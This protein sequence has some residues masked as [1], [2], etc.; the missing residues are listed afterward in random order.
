M[1]DGSQ[2]VGFLRLGPAAVPTSLRSNSLEALGVA[3]AGL[4]GVPDAMHNR[5]SGRMVAL[6]D[7]PALVRGIVA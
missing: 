4:G 6:R 7:Y 5:L 3:T 2:R 1:P